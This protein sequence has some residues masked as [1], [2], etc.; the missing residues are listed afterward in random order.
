MG[1]ESLG[2]W[3]RLKSNSLPFPEGRSQNPGSS[4]FLGRKQR[5][6]VVDKR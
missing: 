2:F 6:P 1:L 4:Q 5:Q 3:Q